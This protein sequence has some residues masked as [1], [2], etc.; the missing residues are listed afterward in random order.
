MAELEQLLDQHR[1]TLT[2][3]SQRQSFALLV[4]KLHLDHRRR[5]V[6]VCNPFVQ[7]EVVNRPPSS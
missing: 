3:E 7:R 2:T 5:E 6:V 4:A 1:L